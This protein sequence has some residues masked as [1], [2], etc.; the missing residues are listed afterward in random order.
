MQDIGLYAP[1]RNTDKEANCKEKAEGTKRAPNPARKAKSKKIAKEDDEDDFD[2]DYDE[3][4]DSS[5]SEDLSEQKA[6]KKQSRVKAAVPTGGQQL[7]LQ[8]IF[9]TSFNLSFNFYM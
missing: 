5:D 2:D 6:S 1:L 8:F 4:G 7:F 9:L 3:E